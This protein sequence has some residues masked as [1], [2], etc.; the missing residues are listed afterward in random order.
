[1]FLLHILMSKRPRHEEMNFFF[2]VWA[3]ISYLFVFNRQTFLYFLITK[4]ESNLNLSFWIMDK[5]SH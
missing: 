3:D 5:F 2:G 1:M 4:S